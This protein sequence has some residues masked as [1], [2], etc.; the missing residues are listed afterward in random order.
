MDTNN[1][2]VEG[3]S[4]RLEICSNWHFSGAGR[5]QNDLHAFRTIN[6]VCIRNDVTVGIEYD[7]G[8]SYMLL[9]NAAGIVVVVVIPRVIVYAVSPYLYFNNGRRNSFRKL[10]ERAVQLIQKALP[11]RYCLC[12]DWL[13]GE[14]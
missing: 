14:H 3:W 11:L 13:Q 6:E 4:R 7:S 2:C 9:H 12:T 8:A 1:C 10:F 5:I